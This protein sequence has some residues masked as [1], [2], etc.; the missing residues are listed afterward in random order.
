[1]STIPDTFHGVTL[2][3]QRPAG[4]LVYLIGAIYS[5]VVTSGGF[6]DEFGSPLGSVIQRTIFVVRRYHRGS[7][8]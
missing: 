6:D 2:C 5:Q 4:I 7:L 3:G 1:M 8:A